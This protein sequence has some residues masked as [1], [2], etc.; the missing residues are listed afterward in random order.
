MVYARMASTAVGTDCR[1]N[2]YQKLLDGVRQAV[3]DAD[4]C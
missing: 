1:P 4:A 3:E 2:A